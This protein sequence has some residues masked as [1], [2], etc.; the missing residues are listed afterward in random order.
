M[1]KDQRTHSGDAQNEGSGALR[2]VILVAL[3]LFSFQRNVLDL[4]KAGIEKAVLAR[5][6]QNLLVSEVQ[7][8]MMILDPQH[9]WRDQL[10]ADFDKKAKEL[11]DEIANKVTSGSLRLVEAQQVLADRLIEVLK[12][13][14][15]GQKRKRAE[16]T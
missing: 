6:L 12:T 14:K 11:L 9:K 2:T 16:P 10:G 4:V 13:L 8:V 7:A 5:P 3:P 15:D 1:P